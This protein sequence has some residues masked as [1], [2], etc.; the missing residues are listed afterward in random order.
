MEK[1]D[2]K[3][4]LNPATFWDTDFEALDM[5]KN[6]YFIIARVAERGTDLEVF[7]IQSVFSKEEILFAVNQSAFARGLSNK[8]KNFF[9]IILS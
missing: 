5:E 2:F 8:T 1:K 9:N 6:K 3:K 7:F 4:Y